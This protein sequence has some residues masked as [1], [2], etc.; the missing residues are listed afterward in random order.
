[1][2]K[3]VGKFIGKKGKKFDIKC[4]I[5][6]KITHIVLQSFKLSKDK[7]IKILWTEGKF[8]VENS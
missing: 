1:M 5:L 4:I 6:L 2:E 3:F 8:K 7:W